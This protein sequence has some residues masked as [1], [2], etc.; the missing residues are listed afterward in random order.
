VL[1]K[2]ANEAIVTASITDFL[3]KSGENR[4]DAIDN[5]KINKITN[6]T[7]RIRKESFSM[8]DSYIRIAVSE[9]ITW[10]SLFSSNIGRLKLS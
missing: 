2:P 1:P 3:A 9:M 4:G 10:F 5:I 7:K 6:N 8:P